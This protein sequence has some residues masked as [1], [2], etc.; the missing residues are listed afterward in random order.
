MPFT[1]KI[2]DHA[3]YVRNRDNP[4]PEMLAHLRKM[5]SC[6]V[7]ATEIY[8]P[9]V[10]SLP[11][12]KRAAGEAGMLLELRVFPGWNVPGVV[13]RQL[14]PGQQEE[15]RKRF[16]IVLLNTCGNHPGNRTASLKEFRKLLEEHHAGIDALSLDFIR[17]DNALLLMDYPCHCDACRALY[18]RYFG[19]E[20]LRGEI[21][22]EPA[23]QYK[24]LAL[25]NAGIR[26]TME[27]VRRL[28]REFGVKLA[29]SARANYLNSIDITDP[30]VWGLGPAVLEGQ[31]WI[32]WMDDGLADEFRVM[33]YHTDFEK[34]RRVFADHL[35]LAGAHLERLTPI[36]GVSSSMGENSPDH[37][38]RQLDLA[39]GTGIR[40]IALFNKSDIYD[41][42]YL[43]L[44]REYAV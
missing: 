9:E 22:K 20:E 23:V 7:R 27:A 12:Y 16:G 40:K 41:E 31:D 11:D 14:L 15:M 37:I 44:I 39:E 10:I 42:R 3:R 18:S 1:F 25:R 35:R 19:R 38:R 21:L 43:N 32:E 30:P 34:Y 28:T 8:M 5:A 36:L 4:F 13:K 33:N 24:L 29:I 6:G 26:R 17:N 2:D